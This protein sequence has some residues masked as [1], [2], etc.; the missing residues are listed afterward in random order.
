MPGEAQEIGADAPFTGKDRSVQV[1]EAVGAGL[2]GGRENK[3]AD[4]GFVGIL[5]RQK[6]HPG[7]QCRVRNRKRNRID[8]ECRIEKLG[9]EPD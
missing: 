8:V 1:V 3:K 7:A 9:I 6:D 5:G 4:D 2:S